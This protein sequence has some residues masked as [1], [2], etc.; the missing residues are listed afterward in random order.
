MNIFAGYVKTKDKKPLEKIKDSEYK[1][2]NTIRQLDCDYGGVLNED[3]IMVDIDDKIEAE[4]LKKLIIEEGVNCWILKTTRGYHFYFKNTIIKENKINTKVVLGLAADIKIGSK[5]TVVPLRIDGKTRTFVQKTEVLD[6][7][8]F[9]L[10]PIKSGKDF[11]STTTRNNDLYT[12]ILPLQGA[13]YSVS[14]IREVLILIN[15]YILD[16]PLDADEIETI[17]RDEAFSKPAFFIKNKFKHDTFSKWLIGKCNIIKIDGMLHY[18]KDQ[19]YINCESLRGEMLKEIP[20]L[21]T[22]QRNEAFSYI[23]DV[24]NTNKSESP[25]RYIN[26]GNGVYDLET[27][28]LIAHSPVMLIANKIVTNYNPGAKSPLIDEV[29]SNIAC[30]D[31]SIVKLIYEMIGYTLYRRNE[32]GKAF[33]LNGT[34]RNGKSTLIKMIEHLLGNVN[35]SVVSLRDLD[36]NFP[37]SDVINKL[38]N[39]GDDIGEEYIDNNE[40][41]KKMITGDAVQFDLKF[42]KPISKQVYTK[43]IFSCNSIP[44]CKDTSYG[45]MKRLIIIPFKADFSI[46][47]D[48]NPYIIDDLTNEKNLEYLLIKGI[49]ALKRVLQNGEFSSSEAVNIE[50]NEYETDNNSVIGFVKEGYKI[51]NE[52]RDEI[53]IKYKDW[54]NLSGLKSKSLS[55]F[56]KELGKLK[57]VV[58]ET[59]INGNKIKYY[60]SNTY[61]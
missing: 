17:L 34:G 46:K 38:V 8:P 48:F 50:L 44:R 12:Y 18:Y 61:K 59:N 4:I 55:N 41:F 56:S 13:G 22:Q 28:E 37:K 15:K 29:I 36:K 14:Q 6:D 27:D 26:V 11:K 40:T 54:C 33:I 2:Y 39:L 16:V 3:I 35:V 43:F 10:E 19:K 32:L 42:T 20:G 58:W 24:I 25:P 9:W 31:E 45:F 60:R 1:T 47:P 30:G 57:I 51:I 23:N 7:L 49:E 53:F 21:T 52:L 5:H